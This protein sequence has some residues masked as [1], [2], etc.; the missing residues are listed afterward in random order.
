MKEKPLN[1]ERRQNLKTQP[2]K[3]LPE[4]SIETGKKSYLNDLRIIYNENAR[5]ETFY[6]DKYDP[7]K[8]DNDTAYLDSIPEDIF[9]KYSRLIS[10]HI[11]Y[12][13]KSSMHYSDQR[14]KD[15]SAEDSLCRDEGSVT[16]AIRKLFMILSRCQRQ[17]FDYLSQ[18]HD[19][20][21]QGHLATPILD[22]LPQMPPMYREI[23]EEL[24]EVFAQNIV[25]KHGEENTN[26]ITLKEKIRENIGYEFK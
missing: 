11:C 12:Y 16:N 18:L 4:I 24:L 13:S 25:E 17:N 26:W 14:V 23:V 6:G 15:L 22:I 8:H 20:F 19:V 1:K 2:T 9:K 5:A 3:S 10:T 21:E 7:N